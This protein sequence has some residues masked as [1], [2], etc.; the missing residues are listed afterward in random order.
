MRVSPFQFHI[1][2]LFAFLALPLLPGTRACAEGLSREGRAAEAVRIVEVYTETIE[3]CSMLGGATRRLC[4][5]EAEGRRAVAFA[6]LDAVAAPSAEHTRTAARAVRETAF[7]T[8]VARCEA[9]PPADVSVCTALAG[10]ELRSA[11][12][13][14]DL[15]YGPQPRP[16]KAVRPVRTTRPRDRKAGR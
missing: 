13:G 12:A 4:T 8:S 9:G 14:A 15:F 5:V 16:A 10:S 7:A 3:H 2:S 6:E 11:R 1:V